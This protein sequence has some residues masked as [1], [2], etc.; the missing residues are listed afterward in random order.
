VKSLAPGALFLVALAVLLWPAGKTPAPQPLPPGPVEILSTDDGFTTAQ[1]SK[2]IWRNGVAQ[3]SKDHAKRLRAGEFKGRDLAG[4]EAFNKAT[5]EAARQ[6][7]AAAT[8]R[9]KRVHAD[10]YKLDE[11]LQEDFKADFYE[12]YGEGVEAR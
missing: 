3:A 10:A 6:A 9:A 4:V 1:K 2:A 12:S 8:E 5:G 7:I 11:H